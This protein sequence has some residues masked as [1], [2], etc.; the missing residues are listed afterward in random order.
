L[1]KLSNVAT[2]TLD[3]APFAVDTNTDSQTVTGIV[4]G[5]DLLLKLSNVATETLDLSSLTNN[6]NNFG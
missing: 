6:S 3:L 1:L 5:T 4:S 2:E